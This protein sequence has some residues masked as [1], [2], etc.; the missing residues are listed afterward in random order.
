ME[1]LGAF[2]VKT[3]LSDLL[4]RVER[5][6]SFTIT[7]NGVPVAKLVPIEERPKPDVEQAITDLLAL[8]KQRAGKGLS[9][10]EVKQLINEG[11]EL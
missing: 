9:A 7:R 11:R 2:E 5:G 4:R 1:S 10:G 6:E 8:R 3:H